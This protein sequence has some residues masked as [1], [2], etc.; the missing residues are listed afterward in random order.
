MKNAFDELSRVDTAKE[1]IS[2]FENV[3]INTSKPKQKEHRL[4]KMNEIFKNCEINA[5]GIA[6]VKKEHQKNRRNL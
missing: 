2:E 3:S 5:R 1:R 4:E 6:Y